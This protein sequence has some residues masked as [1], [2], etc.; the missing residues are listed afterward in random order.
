MNE[1]QYAEVK[2]YVS[3]RHQHTYPT[4]YDLD[5]LRMILQDVEKENPGK[6]VE[7]RIKAC[8]VWD[9]GDPRD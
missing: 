2:V 1:Y 3:G 8:D 5:Q 7:A 6:A 9:E 4:I